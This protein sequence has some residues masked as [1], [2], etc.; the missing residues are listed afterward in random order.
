M[1][2]IG[3][4]IKKLRE[5]KGISLRELAKRLQVSASFISQI[6]TN[7]AYPSLVTLKSI[8][9]AL[10][11]TVGSLIGEDL[12]QNNFMIVREKERKKVC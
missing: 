5:V 10:G 7:K 11:T 2:I 12:N 6:E 3:V 8:A 9:D 4:N 1:K